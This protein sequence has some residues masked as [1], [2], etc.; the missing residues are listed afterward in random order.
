MNKELKLQSEVQSLANGLY[1]WE[2]QKINLY[3]H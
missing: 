3:Y 1:K 2:A